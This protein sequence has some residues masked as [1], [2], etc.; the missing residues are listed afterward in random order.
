MIEIERHTHWVELQ[1]NR[2]SCMNAINIEMYRDLSAQLRAAH[3]DPSVTA[4]IIHGAGPHFCA[5]NDLSELVNA[6]ADTPIA[7]ADFLKSLITADLPIIAAIQGNVVGVGVT[8]LQHCDF[9]YAKS[10]TQFSLPFT[11]L[12]VC[13]EGASSLLFA[14]IVG[15][16]K[17]AR[18]LLD[19]EPFNAEQALEAGLITAI[20][21]P[22]TTPL[23]Q[24]RR[25]ATSL[26][27]KPQGSLRDSKRLMATHQRENQLK[28][29]DDEIEIFKQRLRNAD[30]LEAIQALLS[31]KEP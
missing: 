8:L 29:V 2:P 18:W 22:F 26:A 1:L 28:A 23:E 21:D 11:K 27:Q 12:G 31:S 19:A 9:V 10:D 7:A 4:L 14:Q 6:T 13:P 30:T 20:S 24:A 3:N 16:K 17:A 15:H 5:G 25:R